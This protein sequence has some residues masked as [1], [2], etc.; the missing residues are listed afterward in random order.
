MVYIPDMTAN[1][2]W[3]VQMFDV[4]RSR[5]ICCSRVW[6]AIRR[7]GLPWVSFES[8]MTRPGI[9]LSKILRVAKK[10]ACGPPYPIGTPN[11][12]LVPTTTSAPHS[13]GGFNKA[14]LSKS[15]ATAI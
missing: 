15:A 7:A 10:A 1:N 13:P 4:A 14:R 11:R 8:P 6:S 2:T 9:F 12:W 3:A 5:R